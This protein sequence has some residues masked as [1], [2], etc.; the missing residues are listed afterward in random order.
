MLKTT[1]TALLI[2]SRTALEEAVSKRYVPSADIRN[3]VRVAKKFIQHTAQVAQE[4]ELPLYIKTS[5][6]QVGYTF[7]ERFSNAIDEVF[8]KGYEKVIAIGSDSPDLDK[9]TILLVE[10]KLS[11]NGLVLGPTKDGGVYVV[12]I[13]KE[14]FD[15]STF[16]NIPWQTRSTYSALRSYNRFSSTKSIH[17]LTDI[18]T[19]HDLLEWV[20]CTSQRTS[21]YQ[22]IWLLIYNHHPHHSNYHFQQKEEFQTFCLLRGPPQ[23]AI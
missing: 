7:G 2:F 5:D 1:K 18:D 11:K 8:N 12:G 15:R 19:K 6:Q 21:L 17:I 22:Q 10:K 4:T 9:E 20:Q 3:N 14:I 23:Y 13:Q 16:A